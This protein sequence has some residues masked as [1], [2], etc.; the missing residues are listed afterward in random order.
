[1]LKKV[2]RLE[3]PFFIEKY[4]IYRNDLDEQEKIEELRHSGSQTIED[5]IEKAKTMEA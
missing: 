2:V 5:V 4:L 1:M 3:Q